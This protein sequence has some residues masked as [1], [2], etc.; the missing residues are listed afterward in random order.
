M[1]CNGAYPAPGYVRDPPSGI[2]TSNLR[3]AHRR[4]PTIGQVAARP[5]VWPTRSCGGFVSLSLCVV[6]FGVGF[7]GPALAV[8]SLAFKLF[9]SRGRLSWW[10]RLFFCFAFGVCP[11]GLCAGVKNAGAKRAGAKNAGAKSVWGEKRG[12]V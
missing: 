3:A 9:C 5:W 2:D 7:D 10:S 11:P 4:G 1:T 8:V 12:A 6:V